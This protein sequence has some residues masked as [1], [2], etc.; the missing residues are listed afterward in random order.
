MMNQLTFANWNPHRRP[1]SFGARP[2]RTLRAKLLAG[3][4]ASLPK[5]WQRKWITQ[6]II[7][8]P[9]WADFV[10]IR[11]VYEA[12]AQLTWDTKIFHDVDH[13]VPLNHPRVCGLHVHYN[14]RPM[15][16]GPNNAKSNYWCPE[17]MELAL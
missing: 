17:Q 7:A 14:L 6:R 15:P 10:A 13:I 3:N 16:K 8:T 12:A 1:G 5:S 11:A 2:C 9:P 4:L